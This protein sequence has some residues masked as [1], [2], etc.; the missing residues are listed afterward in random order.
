V[1][2]L[3]TNEPYHSASLVKAVLFVAYL[4]KLESEHRPPAGKESFWLDAM[5]R[6]SDNDSATQ[7]FRR[8]GPEPVRAL[9]RQAGMGSFRI[10]RVWGDSQVTAADEA[11]FFLRIDRLVPAARRGYAHYLLGVVE[12]QQS[13]GIP[14][15]A[16]P[17]WQVFFKGGWR[18]HS[19]VQLVHQ[20]ALL[21]RGSSR[22]GIAVLTDGNPSEEY[23]HATIQ[24]VASRLLAPAAS[25]APPPLSPLPTLADYTPPGAPPVAASSGK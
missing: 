5:I 16:R 19:G 8:L 21:E 23:G 18:P 20:A 7:L 25:S 11:R 2:G 15:A 1:T 24:G 9:A 12:P 3:R 17:R 10:G 13:W 6:V 14:A 22:L 4:R